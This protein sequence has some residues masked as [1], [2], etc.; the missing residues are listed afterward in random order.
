MNAYSCMHKHT[1]THACIHIQSSDTLAVRALIL[2][3]RNIVPVQGISSKP[4]MACHFLL[5][6]TLSVTADLCE[7]EQCVLMLSVS[8]KK[9][10]NTGTICIHFQ[11]EGVKACSATVPVCLKSA[12]AL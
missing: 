7:H 6:V 10:H 12:K 11:M 2:V 8:S 9:T 3:V 5:S 1:Y 4:P